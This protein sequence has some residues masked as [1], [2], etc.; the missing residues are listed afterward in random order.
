M[1]LVL[2][3]LAIVLIA[4]NTREVKIRLV[5]PVVTM[6]LYAALLIMF[7]I[8]LLCGALLVYNRNRNRRHSR[9]SGR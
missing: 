5:V 1:A 8:G 3:A 7:V 2:A 4:E 9:R 6:P